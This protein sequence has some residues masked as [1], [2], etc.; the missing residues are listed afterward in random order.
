METQAKTRPTCGDRALELNDRDVGAFREM[1][2][3]QLLGDQELM[4]DAVAGRE[5]PEARMS[6]YDR[7]CMTRRMAKQVDVD[8]GDPLAAVPSTRRPRPTCIRVPVAALWIT[9]GILLSTAAVYTDYLTT[10]VEIVT[11]YVPWVAFATL[12]FG[13]RKGMFTLLGSALAF[14]AI[15]PYALKADVEGVIGFVAMVLAIW[16]IRRDVFA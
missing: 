1:L 9:L 13:R 14:L 12:R 16:A 15:P 2:R 5:D 4:R 3:Q 6:I 7:M 10:G 11:L 8:L